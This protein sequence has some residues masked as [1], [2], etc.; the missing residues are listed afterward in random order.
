MYTGVDLCPVNV[1]NAPQRMEGGGER[2]GV[3]LS[4]TWRKGEDNMD[5]PTDDLI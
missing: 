5:D 2:S 3:H 4:L 1:V